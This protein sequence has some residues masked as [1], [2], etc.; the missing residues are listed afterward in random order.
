MGQVND[1]SMFGTV[2]PLQDDDVV[3]MATSG[4]AAFPR[5]YRP[6]AFSG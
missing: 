6:G 3:R 5:A 2:L 1:Q 4:V